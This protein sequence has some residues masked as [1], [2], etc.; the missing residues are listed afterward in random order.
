VNVFDGHHPPGTADEYGRPLQWQCA[1]G[2]PVTRP[3]R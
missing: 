3:T 1:P 2:P